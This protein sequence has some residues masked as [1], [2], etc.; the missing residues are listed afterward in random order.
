MQ[1]SKCCCIAAGRIS[2]RRA[3]SLAM[4]ASVSIKAS[5]TRLRCSWLIVHRL[6]LGFRQV[7]IASDVCILSP[8]Q[9]KINT[10][11]QKDVEVFQ[12]SRFAN[13]NAWKKDCGFLARWLGSPVSEP[14]KH[15]GNVGRRLFDGVFR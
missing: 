15:P 2:A 12:N 3:D 14:K 9:T 8:P 1:K 5:C 10:F 13:E 7:S 11:T 6:R 4:N